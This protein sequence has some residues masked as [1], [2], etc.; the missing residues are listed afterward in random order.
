MRNISGTWKHRFSLFFL[1][2]NN[3][4]VK[5]SIYAKVFK[6]SREMKDFNLAKV[7]SP[8]FLWLLAAILVPL[9][10]TPTWRLHTIL[11]DFEWYI[12]PNN[13]STGYCTV[14]KLWEVVYLYLSTISQFL[15]WMISNFTFYLRDVKTK[16]IF[17]SSFTVP[18]LLL[19][20]G[21]RVPA[22]IY[23]EHSTRICC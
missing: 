6:F 1:G 4:Y 2:L 15:D 8:C 16:N 21:T 14:L 20:A 3:Q 5:R 22:P 11:C 10:G 23:C 7:N 18:G 17:D 9:K 13:S 19:E 12:L